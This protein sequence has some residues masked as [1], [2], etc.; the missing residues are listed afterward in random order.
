MQLNQGILGEDS[1]T[2]SLI[3]CEIG[4]WRALG[5]QQATFDDGLE[6]GVEIFDGQPKEAF[7]TSDF[8][9]TEM[10]LRHLAPLN[11]NKGLRGTTSKKISC[12]NLSDAGHTSSFLDG[13]AWHG[14]KD[15]L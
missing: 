4:L 1:P 9:E 11:T 12:V 2:H 3:P 8:W 6:I 15:L 7:P 10:R 13:L 14:W 5:S